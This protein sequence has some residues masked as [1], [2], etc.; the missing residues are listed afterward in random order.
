MLK[1]TFPNNTEKEVLT[2]TSVIEP[3]SEEKDHGELNKIFQSDAAKEMFQDTIVLPDN[4]D[5]KTVLKF[6]FKK[7]DKNGDNTLSIKELAKYINLMICDHIDTSIKKNPQI[8]SEIDKMPI[9]G[10]VTWN[11]YHA[12][13][14][15]NL[16]MDESYIKNHDEKN[17]V[18][19][20][21]KSKES[22]M[23]DKARWTEVLSSDPQSLTLDEFL[24]FQHPESSTSNLLNLVEDILRHFD[25]DGDDVLSVEEFTST[26]GSSTSDNKKM[27]LSDNIE[28]RKAEFN[29]LIDKNHDGK[30]DRGELL[31]FVDPR[32]SRY[33]I[34]EAATLFSLADT[35]LDKKLT[36]D[37]M[38]NKQEL[39][40]TSKFISLIENFHNEF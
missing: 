23:R 38:L 1:I 11:E 20:D 26:F 7:A 27:F 18:K 40:M 28:E 6:A 37:E 9:D 19:L 29:K 13:F 34:Q 17:H 3:E 5:P 24:Q 16:K 21:R 39:F 35:N 32:N 8:F 25:N 10:M 22:L 33:A 12:Y 15:K 31:Q 2:V 30:A 14:L 36:V 4:T